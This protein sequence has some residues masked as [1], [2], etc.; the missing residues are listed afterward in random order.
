VGQ[1]ALLFWLS[2]VPSPPPGW[3][4]PV[5]DLA[6]FPLRTGAAADCDAYF[7]LQTCVITRTVRLVAGQA[8]AP[9][10]RQDFSGAVHRRN[11][12]RIVATGW[13]LQFTLRWR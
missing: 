1:S 10:S 4:K 7:I 2:L 9:T 3:R 8:I 5:R 11:R 12:A 6:D 13:R